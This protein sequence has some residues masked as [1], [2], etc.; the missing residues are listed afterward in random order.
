[1]SITFTSGAVTV[2]INRGIEHTSQFWFKRINHNTVQ[3]TDGS[4][5]TFDN[6]ST[7]LEG[8]IK[9]RYLTKTDADS[10]RNFIRNTIR[11]SRNTL[12]I[13][14]ASYDDL[15]GGD[16]VA[17][18]SVNY[19]GDP[20]TKDIIVPFGKAGKYNVSFPYRTFITPS[21]STADADG[22]AA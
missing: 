12:T 18:T 19:I 2:T 16:G 3:A 20:D 22:N 14:P 10:L 17:I 4:L 7:V 1:M 11:F 5:I 9:I 8:V 15:G 6:S 21:A 13:T